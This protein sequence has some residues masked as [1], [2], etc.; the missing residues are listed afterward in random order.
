MV[1]P[2]AKSTARL[3]TLSKLLI[4]FVRSGAPVKQP[5]RRMPSC[6]TNLA[7]IARVFIPLGAVPWTSAEPNPI[8]RSPNEPT[9]LLKTNKAHKKTNPNEPGSNGQTVFSIQASLSVTRIQRVQGVR[10]GKF[11]IFNE[12]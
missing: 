8:G 6:P 4:S 2:T 10:F 7:T 5:A 11:L 9:K 1:C 12:K 3:K